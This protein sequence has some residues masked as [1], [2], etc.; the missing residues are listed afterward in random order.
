MNW[1]HWRYRNKGW[2]IWGQYPEL[3]L[4]GEKKFSECGKLLVAY[5][6]ILEN[7]YVMRPIKAWDKEWWKTKE[8]TEG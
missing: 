8:M 5:L 7:D 3:Q 6:V 2:H 4:L 1:K